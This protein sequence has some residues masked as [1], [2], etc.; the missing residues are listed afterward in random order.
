MVNGDASQYDAWNEKRQH[1][2]GEEWAAWIT[3]CHTRQLHEQAGLVERCNRALAAAQCKD[4]P[5][6]P[7]GTDIDK[8]FLA[9]CGISTEGL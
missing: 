6:L 3:S 8:W 5:T 4:D 1:M 2:T 7:L 9:A